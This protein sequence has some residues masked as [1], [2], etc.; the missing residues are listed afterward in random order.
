MEKVP[1]PSPSS[2]LAPKDGFFPTAGGRRY[3]QC[4]ALPGKLESHHQDDKSTDKLLISHLI[5][6]QLV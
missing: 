1:H 6:I 5:Y 3:G 4:L 2:L